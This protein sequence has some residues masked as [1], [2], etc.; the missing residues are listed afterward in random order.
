LGQAIRPSQFILSYGVGSIVEAPR[1][2]RVIPAFERWDLTQRIFSGS[3]SR[4]R[5]IEDRNASAQL[6]GG[7]IFEIPTNTQ[8]DLVD[9][10]PLFRTIRFPRWGLCQTHRILYRLGPQGRTNCPECRG[11]L[12]DFQHEAI[13]FVRACPR[14]HLDDVDWRRTVHGRKEC[15]GETFDWV[16]ET[17]SDLRSVQLRCRTCRVHVS[18]LDVYY[19][20]GGWSCSGI[21]QELGRSEPCDE[22]ASVVLRSATSLRVADIVTS[23]TIPPPALQI[24]N[25][26][27]Q[28]GLTMLSLAAS[29]SDPK[30]RLLTDLKTIS[31]A[32]PGDID[33]ATIAEIESTP[34]SEVEQAIHDLLDSGTGSK[35]IDQVKQEEFTALVNA[36][37]SGYPSRPSTEPLF[38]VDRDSVFRLAHR[39]GLKFRI[40]PIKRLRV[41]LVQ[42][43][44]RRPVRGPTDENGHP[45]PL[46][47]TYLA[48]GTMRW[49][50]G[51]ALYGEGVFIDLP[52]DDLQLDGS[53]TEI[54]TERESH[55]PNA[56]VYNPSFVW[57]HTL[58]HRLINALAIDSGYSS[59]AIRERVYLRGPSTGGILLYTSQQGSDGSL[60]GLIA[61]CN[62]TDIQGVISAAERDINSCSNDPLCGKYVGRDNGAACYAC[63]LISE[64]SCEYHNLY[65]DRLLLA[66]SLMGR[67]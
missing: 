34:P 62:R 20:K 17:G 23:L 41:V 30:N 42:H 36:A 44:Y 59:A 53:R 2:P 54:W 56:Y 61:L 31:Q 67:P 55:S 37:Q 25:L 12:G 18:L 43:G 15:P 27:G 64:T 10:Q 63:L 16:E 32:R 6:N 9:S 35:T 49:F 33:L 48:R 26:L 52:D 51:V 46:V 66:P 5:R 65:L 11:K 45:I 14:G 47:E 29:T 22:Q 8:F 1:G 28:L 60:G 58:A 7:E 3:M 24:H 19:R 40:T 39:S 50:P 13:R 21:V 4:L 57:W 38:E